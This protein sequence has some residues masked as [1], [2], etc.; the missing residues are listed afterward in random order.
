MMTLLGTGELRLSGG[1]GNGQ[2]FRVQGGFLQVVDDQVR[3]VT[4]QAT[5]G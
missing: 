5:A 2:R 1:S 3:V 4:E